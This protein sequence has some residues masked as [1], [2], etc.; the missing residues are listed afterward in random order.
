MPENLLK[1]YVETG[2][3]EAIGDQPV[4][5]YAE[6]KAANAEPAVPPTEQV[7]RV[8]QAAP[9]AR[10]TLDTLPV[11]DLSTE[12]RR[13][14]AT[15]N[16]LGELREALDKF[17]GC[18]LKA[19]AKNLVFAD[20]NPTAP[21]MLVGEAPGAEEDRQGL[22]FVGASGQLLDKMLAAI[23]LDRTS[24]YIANILP[25]RP[26][27]NRK[28]TTQET[29]TCLPFI[30]RHIELVGPKVLV[31]LGGTSASTLLD[32]TEG[33]TRLRGKWQTYQ[34]GD[35]EI[36]ALPTYHPAYLLRQPALKRDSWRDL[37]ALQKRLNG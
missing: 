4:N 24:V 15:C 36:P 3:D 35:Q 10:P 25:W 17:D 33:I 6:P 16:T 14:A 29:L 31:F 13:L 21:L 28:P 2:A 37:Q 19:T 7:A 9:V 20:G 12:A 26:P 22:P 18:G 8:A 11:G 23:G 27:G 1:W 30:E 5:R 34:A 32:T